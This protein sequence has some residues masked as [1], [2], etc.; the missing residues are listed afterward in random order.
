M[1]PLLVLRSSD[2]AADLAEFK[3]LGLRTFAPFDFGRKALMPD[4]SAV[5]VGFALGFVQDPLMVET[6]FFVCQHKHSPELFWK[7]NYQ[8][9]QNGADGLVS[10]LF[11][12]E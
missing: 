9:H 10:V 8:T 2:R 4:G 11:V 6:G 5:E 3:A 1:P 7:E 12:A